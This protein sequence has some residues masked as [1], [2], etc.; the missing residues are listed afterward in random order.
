MDLTE[1]RAFL[2]VAETG[3][4]AAA[5]KRTGVPR[6]TLRRRLD[7]LEARA[8][9]ALLHRTQQGTVLTPAGERFAQKAGAILEDA[10]ALLRSVGEFAD[11][12]APLRVS[13]P[14]GFPPA[15]LVR[16]FTAAAAAF[17][18]SALT[19]STANSLAEVALD[20][21]DVAVHF[22]EPKNREHW[23]SI[24]L[25]QLREWLVA[26]PD[27]LARR[28]R[29]S[30]IAELSD[31]TL[32]SWRHPTEPADQ[33][34]TVHG[35]YF[36]VSLRASHSDIHVLHHAAA[37]GI[38]IALVP[39]AEVDVDETHLPGPP[40]ETLLTDQVGRVVQLTLSVPEIIADT[41]RVASLIDVIRDISGDY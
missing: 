41:P 20:S 3:S 35:T 2:S 6:A 24:P 40:L 1:I 4:L 11:D 30:T 22:G 8:G 12:P 9:V 19:F 18:A 16:A 26:S 14:V 5:A 15:V 7:E 36:P 34:P 29:P 13:H 23:L 25:M 39:D 10:S 38:G 32:L 28:G 37:S 17:P 27:Y 31:H 33:W 21:V